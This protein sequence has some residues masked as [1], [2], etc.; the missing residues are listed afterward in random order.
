LHEVTIVGIE[1][2]SDETTCTVRVEVQDKTGRTD[3]DVGS[4]AMPILPLN[5]SDRAA[6]AI[7]SSRA[8][9]RMQAVEKAKMRATFSICCAELLC[10]PELEI[11]PLGAE[12]LALIKSARTA[13]GI[14]QSE[15]VNLIIHKYGVSHP[16]DLTSFQADELIKHLNA[17][18][19]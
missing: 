9:A 17:R 12:I 8:T 4:V 19:Q 7:A 5:S 11:E 14:E 10:C 13:A 2:F 15:L 1:E 18:S 16:Q 6:K 3:F